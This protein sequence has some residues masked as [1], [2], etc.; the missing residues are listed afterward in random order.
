MRRLVPFSLLLIVLAP[1]ISCKSK[2]TPEPPAPV[3]TKV[4]PKD[5]ST[6]VWIPAGTFQM[7]CSPGDGECESE[8]RPAHT[9][10]ISKGFWM[11]QTEVTQAAYRRVMGTNPSYVDGDRLPVESVTWDEANAYCTAVGMRLPTEA[12]W[13]YAARA[14]STT[15]R[16]GDLDGI[17]W[18][19]RNSGNTTHEVGQKQPNRWKLYDMLG[20]VEEWAADWFDDNYYGR[21]ASQDPPG[22]SAGADRVVRG[23]SYLIG[24]WSARASARDSG[25]PEIRDYNHGFRCIGEVP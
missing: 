11:G 14:G 5:G 6:Y 8:E 22:P 17:A 18:Y 16:H 9:V 20:N 3:K 25:Y 21:S 19:G 2:S 7:G 4:N 13:E 10:T 15:P 24:S 12:E 23:G 1:T